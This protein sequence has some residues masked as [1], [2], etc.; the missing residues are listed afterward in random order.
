[1]SDAVRMKIMR[2]KSP[3]LTMET[4]TD[5]NKVSVT[6]ALAKLPEFRGL[7]KGEASI[8]KD[9]EKLVQGSQPMSAP[10]TTGTAAK[11]DKTPANTG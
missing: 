7:E 5:S 4:D 1:M 6:A 8:G 11:P 10:V 2:H 3:R 9:T